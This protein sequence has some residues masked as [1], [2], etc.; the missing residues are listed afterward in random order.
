MRKRKFTQ[1]ARSVLRSRPQ[2]GK[3][4]LVNQSCLSTIQ[5]RPAL[6]VEPLMPTSQCLQRPVPA[7]VLSAAERVRGA[8]VA[9]L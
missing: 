8:S 1:K 4:V 7:H 3:F 5:C 6:A 9:L 2:L